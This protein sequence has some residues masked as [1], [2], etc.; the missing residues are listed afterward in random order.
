MDAGPRGTDGLNLEAITRNVAPTH[1]RTFRTRTPR[2]VHT[3]IPAVSHSHSH[4]RS[5]YRVVRRPP[6][7]SGAAVHSEHANER[8][9]HHVEHVDLCRRRNMPK[10]L[11][12]DGSAVFR[13]CRSVW[14]VQ[15][16][17]HADLC[18]QCSTLSMP[19]CV[20][21]ATLGEGRSV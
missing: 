10:M 18:G 16:L 3:H 2:A 19:I 13:G 1:T 17:G 7:K 6:L 5:R 9:I 8:E 20:A 21:S 11:K 4:T 14:A 12:C 15:H